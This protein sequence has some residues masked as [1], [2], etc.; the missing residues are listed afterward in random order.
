VILAAP[1]TPS[2]SV[3]ICRISSV[4]S[5]SIFVALLAFA[6]KSLVTQQPVLVAPTHGA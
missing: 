3:W 5:R 1:Y 4:S 2:L 6:R